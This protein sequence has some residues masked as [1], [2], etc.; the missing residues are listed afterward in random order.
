MKYAM[1]FELLQQKIEQATKQAFLEMHLQHGAEGIYAFALYS[2]EGAMTVCPSTNTQT[3]LKAYDAVEDRIYYQFEPAEWK[4]EMQGA[5]AAFNQIS[6]EVYA[7]SEQCLQYDEDGEYIES[8]A[9]NLFRET[10]FD[11][12]FK[13]LL[14]LK[15]ENFFYNLVQNDVF[16]MF[17]VSE[18]EFDQEKLK[19]MII[20]LND[21][22]YQ[23][24]YLAWMQTWSEWLSDYNWDQQI[25]PHQPV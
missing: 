9:F 18:Y 11:C 7:A 10:L 5:D 25:C 2:D 23:T 17:S 6:A 13:V 12:C 3:A 1:N 19:K 14:K 21:N 16:L 22:P 20:Q 4:Y 24:E 15:Q 8:E